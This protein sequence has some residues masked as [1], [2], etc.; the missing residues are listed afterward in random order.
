MYLCTYVVPRI[1]CRIVH[2]DGTSTTTLGTL[3]LDPG[4][5]SG[6]GY[7]AVGAASGMVMILF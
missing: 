2:D 6:M 5:G 3:S 4:S 1:V 7:M